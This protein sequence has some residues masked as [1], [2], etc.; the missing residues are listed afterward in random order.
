[1]QRVVVGDRPH[2][3]LQLLELNVEHRHFVDEVVPMQ[4]MRRK[5]E[6]RQE[7]VDQSAQL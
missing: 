2:L 6:R 3:F 7:L 1:M 5:P 4:C